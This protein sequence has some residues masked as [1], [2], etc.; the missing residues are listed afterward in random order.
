MVRGSLLLIRV[1]GLQRFS[2][3]GWVLMGMARFG[4]VL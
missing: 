3:Y 1:A 2:E 4:C